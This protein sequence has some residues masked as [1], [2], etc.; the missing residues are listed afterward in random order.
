MK[1]IRFTH[2]IVWD[3]LLETIVDIPFRFI[4]FTHELLWDVFLGKKVDVLLCSFVLP[5]R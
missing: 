2:E 3:V 4:R 1:F 5:M